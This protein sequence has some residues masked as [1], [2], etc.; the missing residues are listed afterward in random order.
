L[1][2]YVSK[3]IGKFLYVLK[4]KDNSYVTKQKKWKGKI[5]VIEERVKTSIRTLETNVMKA[6]TDNKEEMENKID[7]HYHKMESILQK[8][9]EEHKKH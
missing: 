5:N 8:I 4:P 1:C 6:I 3:Q 7:Q 9:L 2:D